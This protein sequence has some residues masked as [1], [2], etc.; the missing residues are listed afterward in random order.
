VA[1]L[2]A[3]LASEKLENERARMRSAAALLDDEDPDE[4]SETRKLSRADGIGGEPGEPSL[5][6]E[7]PS[8]IRS[9][10]REMTFPRWLGVVAALLI[11]ALCTALLPTPE[12]NPRAQRGA[13]VAAERALAKSVT[14][15]ASAAKPKPA[16]ARSAGTPVPAPKSD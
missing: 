3:R 4:R 7:R 16:T 6:S 8:V 2:V 9:A 10:L 1:K 13:P 14:R 5:L 12:P 15:P 11:G